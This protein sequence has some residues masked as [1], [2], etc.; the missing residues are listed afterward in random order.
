MNAV[1]D[2]D[3]PSALTAAGRTGASALPQLKLTAQGLAID[4]PDLELGE[5]LMA[6]ALGVGCRDAMYGI[7][8]QLVKASA[9]RG[10]ADPAN[11]A[12]MLTIVE[13]IKPRDSI[14]AMLVT[15]MVS[16]H[17]MTMRCARDLACAEDPV[18][19]ESAGRRLGR[20]AR[21]FPAQIEALSRYRNNGAPAVTVQNVSVQD[22]GNA[23]VGNVTQHAS[24]MVPDADAGRRAQA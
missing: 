13:S 5:R 1:A 15:Q 19:Q 8:Q 12:F 17:V 10:K 6:N 3:Q 23:I 7:L 20:L 2:P 11:L 24:M 16:L 18:R 4:H 9:N 22:G 14:E 21:T